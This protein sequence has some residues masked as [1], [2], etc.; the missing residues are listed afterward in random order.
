MGKVI[1]IGA[2][3][4]IIGFVLGFALMFV[5]AR[6]MVNKVRWQEEAKHQE[7]L[8]QYADGA[9]PWIDVVND[10]LEAVQEGKLSQKSVPDQI[11]IIRRVIDTSRAD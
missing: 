10:I 8:N 2:L 1:L 5:V 6:E 4:V 11:K 9:G 7:L 3:C